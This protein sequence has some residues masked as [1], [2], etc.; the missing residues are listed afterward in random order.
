MTLLFLAPIAAATMGGCS[1]FD[2]SEIGWES[3]NSLVTT[4][5]PTYS[6][7]ENQIVV[8]VKLTNSSEHT[9]YAPSGGTPNP[10]YTLEKEVDGEWVTAVQTFTP[11]ILVAPLEVEP[12]QVIVTQYVLSELDRIRSWD[13]WLV[14]E[15]PGRYRLVAQLQEDRGRASN[16]YHAEALPLRMRA[17]NPFEITE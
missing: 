5:R 16:S 14:G 15:V 2:P 8:E 13:P 11:A 1:F 17:S 9:V 7:Q 6:P 12:G 3:E 4:D 10:R